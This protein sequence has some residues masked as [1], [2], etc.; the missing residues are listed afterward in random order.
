MGFVESANIAEALAYKEIRSASSGPLGE[1][2]ESLSFSCPNQKHF[3]TGKFQTLSIQPGAIGNDDDNDDG[4]VVET[5]KNRKSVHRS[6][7]EA[8]TSEDSVISD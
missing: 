2:R 7:G 8:R 4:N 5:Y 1:D 3:F 6:S